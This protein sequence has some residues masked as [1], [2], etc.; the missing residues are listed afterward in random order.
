MKFCGNCDMRLYLVSD[1]YVCFN[2]HTHTPFA[3]DQEEVV[4]VTYI[5]N[6]AEV[7]DRPISKYIAEDCTQ[8]RLYDIKCPKADCRSNTDRSVPSE[9]TFL[10]TNAQRL[11]YVYI[12]CVCNTNWQ[13][14]K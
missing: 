10:E 14:K 3:T 6:K 7:A 11:E 13:L 9:I 12:C 1:G 8:P 4:S 2:C 5:R